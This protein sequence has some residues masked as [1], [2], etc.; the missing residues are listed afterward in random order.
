MKKSYRVLVGLTLSL[1]L[2][3]AGPSVIAKGS[4]A[5]SDNPGTIE[6]KFPS[7][8]DRVAAVSDIHGMY[9]SLVT[10]LRAG[11]IMD[12][13]NKWSAGKTLLVVTGDSIDKGGDIVDTV[14]LWIS[15][16]DQAGP[17]GGKVIHLL[18]NHEA[19]FLAGPKKSEKAE[20]FRRELDA[21]GI[22]LKEYTHSGH[23]RADFLLSMPVAAKVGK[24]LFCHAGLM[25]DMSWK[26]LTHKAAKA[27]QAGN[28]SAP[29]LLGTDSILAAKGWWET[30]EGRKDLKKRLSAADMYG[31]V[32][33]HQ[34]KAL[35]V[36]GA[37]A[38][39]QDGRIVKIDN[40]MPPEAGLHP[41]SLLVFPNPSEMEAGPAQMLTVSPDGAI[42]PLLPK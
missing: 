25:P 30:P 9:P 42:T 5:V 2:L 19:E 32:F 36:V 35:S 12:K 17:D 41:G 6:I 4:D 13:N 8:Y 11:G 21:K 20:G 37:S 29:I 26:D 34:P 22:P 18:G 1:L 40:G 39:T 7:N 33:G 23:S 28:Y 24:W 38:V 15:L 31:V 3:N 16:S 10:L 27:L 14:D